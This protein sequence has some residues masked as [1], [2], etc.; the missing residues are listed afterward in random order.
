VMALLLSFFIY[1]RLRDTPKD[2][3]LPPVEHYKGDLLKEEEANHDQRITMSEVIQ[4][5]IKNPL[6]WYISLA[7]LC[8]YIPRMGVLNWAPTFL[9]EYKGATLLEAGWQSA[10]FEVAGLVGGILAGYVSD[11]FFGGRRGP[12]G[13]LCL[14]GLAASMWLLWKIPAGHGLLD[15]VALIL[16]GAFVYGPQVLA[17]IA[18]A[19]FASKRAVGV[20]TGFMGVLGYLGSAISGVGIGKIVDQH[21]W[22]YGFILFIITSLIGAFFFALT[23]GHGARILQEGRINRAN[24]FEESEVFEDD[25]ATPKT[26]K[27]KKNPNTAPDG[28]PQKA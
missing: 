5:V 16:A 11:R 3:G 19:D 1:N 22:D 23:W 12:V 27:S 15:T 25:E 13:A 26:S 7:N 8:L 28:S 17:G 14:L 9:K 4:L 6:V 18:I 21:G 20:A 10:A 2:V 24:A